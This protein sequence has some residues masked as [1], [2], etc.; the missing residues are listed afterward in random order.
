MDRV[1]TGFI[2]VV[3]GIGVGVAE[4][5]VVIFLFIVAIGAL[6]GA[7]PNLI[8]TIRTFRTRS[9]LRNRLLDLSAQ[10]FTSPMVI[11]SL[12]CNIPVTITGGFLTADIL[13][14]ILSGTMSPVALLIPIA[15]L[16]AGG[17]SV[18]AMIIDLVARKYVKKNL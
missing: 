17:L 13:G 15:I 9:G 14:S 2:T 12:I 5:A 18:T 7:I 3:D 8:Y 11:V 16:I 4:A 10:R 1:M 6:I